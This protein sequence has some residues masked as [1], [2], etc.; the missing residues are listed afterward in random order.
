[1][2]TIK[3]DKAILGLCATSL[4]LPSCSNYI[5]DEYNINENAI[6]GEFAK[7]IKIGSHLFNINDTNMSDEA[8]NTIKKL[9]DFIELLLH[10][11]IE[12]S[13]F[14]QN[15]NSYLKEHNI[16]LRDSVIGAKSEALIKVLANPQTI[17]A[18]KNNDAELFIKICKEANYFKTIRPNIDAQSLRNYFKS[19]EEYNNFLITIKNFTQNE[20]RAEGF[21]PNPGGDGGDGGDGNDGDIGD[22]DG[23]DI[24]GDAGL[25]AVAVALVYIAVG[26]AIY[27]GAATIAAL[28]VGVYTSVG[29]ISEDPQSGNNDPVMSLWHNKNGN[30]ADSTFYEIIHKQSEEIADQYASLFKDKEVNVEAVKQFITYNLSGIYGL[31]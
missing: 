6:Y 26:A 28:T 27:V 13:K 21:I 18:I 29:V 20:S 24:G 14:Q 30:T 17:T 11:P 22:G 3:T 1:M 7:N 15:P 4:I 19:E 5:I 9:S 12:A 23:G 10:N 2:K 8:I 16:D 25:I 31:K